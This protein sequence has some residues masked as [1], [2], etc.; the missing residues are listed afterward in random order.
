MASTTATWS[1]L[2]S[3][4]SLAGLA[5]NDDVTVGGKF[6]SL[7]RLKYLSDKITGGYTTAKAFVVQVMGPHSVKVTRTT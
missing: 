7:T 2:G 4:P 5:V 3:P 6:S 1:N